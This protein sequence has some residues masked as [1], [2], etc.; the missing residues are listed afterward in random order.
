MS[1]PPSSSTLFS[2][3]SPSSLVLAFLVVFVWNRVNQISA[4]TQ[5]RYS[6]RTCTAWNGHRFS[7]KF[8]FKQ[9]LHCIDDRAILRGT[10]KIFSVKHT[11]EHEGLLLLYCTIHTFQVGIN[12]FTSY[13][14]PLGFKFHV[15]NRNFTKPLN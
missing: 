12:D 10:T 8:G 3:L 2:S 5:S 13:T 9:F 1:P 14:I 7:Q 6:R 15:G 11:A 4:A